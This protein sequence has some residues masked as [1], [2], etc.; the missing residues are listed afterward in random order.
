M[1]IYPNFQEVSL[2]LA[3]TSTNLLSIYC[4]G[5]ISLKFVERRKKSDINASFDFAYVLFAVEINKLDFSHILDFSFIFK[6]SY[7]S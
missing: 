6:I 3:R 7:L 5:K 1:Y 2:S 4:M